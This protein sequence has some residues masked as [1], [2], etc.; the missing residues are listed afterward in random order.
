[1]FNPLIFSG[2]YSGVG[3]TQNAP[4]HLLGIAEA[5]L[6]DKAKADDALSAAI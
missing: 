2:D 6:F 4:K 5:G 3:Q 1:L